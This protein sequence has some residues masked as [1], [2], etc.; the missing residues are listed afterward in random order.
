MI[1]RLIIVTG[2]M[3]GQRFTVTDSPFFIGRDPECGLC[4]QDADVARKHAIVHLGREGVLIRDLG[5]MNRIS[6]NNREVHEARLKHGDEVE[7]GRTR[8]VVQA[9]VEADVPQRAD[10]R[11]PR[12]Q[13]MRAAAAGL[14]AL[15]VAAAL[16]THATRPAPLPAPPKR[17][18]PNHRA[19]TPTTA[20]S[21]GV[22]AAVAAAL[23]RTPVT[24]T[25]ST[26]TQAPVSEEI[27]RLSSDLMALRTTVQQ[28]AA[29]SASALTNRAPAVQVMI[30]T[31]PAPVAVQAPSP[32]AAPAT[33]SVA[34]SR[35][36]PAVQREPVFTGRVEIASLTQQK[37][38]TSDDYDEMRVVEA[39]LSALPPD[40]APRSDLLRVQVLFFDR[41]APTGTPIRTHALTRD[42]FPPAKQGWQTHAV[43]LVTATYVVP[44]GFRRQEA[45]AGRTEEFYGYVVRVF[46]GNELQAEEARPRDLARFAAPRPTV[47]PSTTPEVQVQR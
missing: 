8:F 29:T 42:P 20:V 43:N 25:P 10:S 36:T 14:A 13:R 11:K 2:P 46:Y 21:T 30:V 39:G 22:G 32:A 33:A 19:P 3:T 26:E 5:T 45:L 35:P 16:W 41:S 27:R 40:A 4:I 31:T 37:F 15:L 28:I 1:Y 18:A 47:I 24:N 7:I 6:V 34:V 17:P 9:V 23:P 38:P 12:R 44:K